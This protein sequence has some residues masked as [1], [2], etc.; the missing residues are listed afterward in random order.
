MNTLYLVME[1]E[2]WLE[3]YQQKHAY[4][5]WLSRIVWYI[6]IGCHIYMILRGINP[7][8]MV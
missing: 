3:V 7:Y 2:D 5:R 1:K 4:S 6:I 8:G